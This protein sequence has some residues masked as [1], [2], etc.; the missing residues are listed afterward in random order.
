LK[1][2]IFPNDPIRTYFEKGEIKPNYF[3]PNNIFDEIHVISLIEN[4]VDKEKIRTLFGKASFEIHAVGE[5][6]IR[7][8]NKDKERILNIVRKIEPS[9]IRAYNPLTAGWLAAYC[10]RKLNIPL[11]VSIHVQYDNLRKQYKFYDVK[12]YLKLKYSE[13]RIEPQVLKTATKITAVY[14]I[15]DMYVNRLSGKHADILYN[16]IEYDRF[17]NAK[18]ILSF[19]KPLVI[20]VGRLTKQKHH[21]IVIHAMKQVNAN[22]LIIGDGELKNE[23]ESLVKKLKLD[24]KVIFKKSIPNSEIQDYYKSA[25]VFVLAYDTSIE[26]LPIPVMEAMATGLPVVIPYPPKGISE[27]L[28]D[29]AKFVERNSNAVAKA[30]NELLADITL[31]NDLAKKSK[32]KAKEFDVQIVENKEASIYLSL[33]N[34]TRD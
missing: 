33:V 9:V 11:F 20:S 29:V 22:L 26:G 27:G 16:R 28:E 13:N 14:K 2:C 25:Q 21:D 5:I 34:M 24:E 7:D 8:I 32:E 1:L 23:L 3:N 31:Y 6:G 10:S 12:K 19:D 17:A 30:I 18:K 15:I 4:D